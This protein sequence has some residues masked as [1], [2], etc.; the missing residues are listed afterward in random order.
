M[1]KEI[2]ETSRR[3]CGRAS[4]CTLQ[5]GR[6]KDVGCCR[7]QH[8]KVQGSRI[9]KELSFYGK[10]HKGRP[11]EIFRRFKEFFVVYSISGLQM[12]TL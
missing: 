7:C 5:E 12:Q 6:K 2:I 3:P 8:F 10:F 11:L 4:S 1:R 9:D